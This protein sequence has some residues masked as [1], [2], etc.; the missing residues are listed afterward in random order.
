MV[1]ATER[2]PPSGLIDLFGLRELVG[3]KR[4]NGQLT[5]CGHGV[6]QVRQL[7][8]IGAA[9]PYARLLEDTMVRELFP[10]LHQCIREIGAVQIQERGTMGGN[11]VTS[12]PVGDTLPVLLALQAT[13]ELASVGSRRTVAYDDFCTGYRTTALKPDEIVVAIELPVPEAGAR[14]YWRKVGT[15]RAQAIS[16]VMVAGTGRCDGAGSIVHCRLAMGAVADR[17]VR[18]PEVEQLL[19][20]Q[21]PDQA[22]ADRANELVRQLIEP[23]DDVRSSADY[24]LA[25]AGNLAAQFVLSLT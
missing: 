2:P 22:L 21:R 6:T 13:V 17:P 11:I 10:A 8:R 15:R 4:D 16:K 20:G 7:V 24:R 25:V 18:L 1:G 12:S 14:Q 23:I 9:T 5:H 19:V 3:V